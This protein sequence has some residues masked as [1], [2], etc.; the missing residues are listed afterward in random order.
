MDSHIVLRKLLLH[1]DLSTEE[2]N[3][4]LSLIETPRTVEAQRVMV[5]EES[6]PQHS[7]VL[8]D[9]FACRFKSLTGDRRQ[10]LS[11]QIPGDISDV[12]SY[13]LKVMDHS[14]MTL[15]QS[16]VAEMKHDRIR[17]VC[18][19]F[20]NLTHVIWRDTMVESAIFR[21]WLTT[22]GQL[23][24]VSRVAHLLCEQYFRLKAV[25]RASGNSV[26]LP[27][28]QSDIADA[29]GISVV[30]ANRT[31]QEL[32]QMRLIELRS[33]TLTILDWEQLAKIGVF[34]QRYLHYRDHHHS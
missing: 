28:T 18:E 11:F 30:H 15:T 31:L 17:E 26:S 13:I 23:P 10:I 6:A 29:L 34:R 19:R 22:I 3:A 1:G 14:V 8:L 25:G 9:G 5:E 24:A 32:R 4:F 27:L 2:K 33:R 16:I 20:P 12:H 21:E 7:L